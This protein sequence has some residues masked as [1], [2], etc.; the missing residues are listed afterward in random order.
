LALNR[1]IWRDNPELEWLPDNVLARLAFARKSL[2]RLRG[3]ARRL[4]TPELVEGII[5]ESDQI[6]VLAGTPGGEQK[7]ANLRKL[8]EMCRE[9]GTLGSAGSEEFTRRLG[10]LVES[11]PNEAKAPLLGEEAQVVR[12]MT[13]HQSKGL[14]FPLVILPDLAGNEGR[15][16][17]FTPPSVDGLFTLPPRDF[18]SDKLRPNPI[19]N[20]LRNLDKA[21][22][23]AE[24]ARLF[25][26]ACTRA[27]EQLV[28]C[29]NGSKRQTSWGKWV[30]Q[31]VLTDPETRIVDSADLGEPIEQS[32]ELVQAAPP[33]TEIAWEAGQILERSLNPMP[34]AP[35]LIRESVSGLEDWFACPRRYYYTRVLG[36]DTAVLTPQRALSKG[37]APPGQA[38]ALGSQ[39]HR[40]LEEA[41]LWQGP[42]SLHELSPDSED[43]DLARELAGGI[44][45]TELAEI[46]RDINPEHM[47]REQGFTLRIDGQTG[48]DLEIIGEID[49]LMLHSQGIRVIDYKVSRHIAPH[50][51]RVQLSLYALAAWRAGG[52]Q[53][54]IPKAGIC[55]LKESGAE[56]HWQS[57]GK[58]DLK[59]LELDLRQA[60][61]DIAALPLEPRL[62]DFMRGSGCGEACSLARAGLC[63]P[64]E[65]D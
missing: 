35:G 59:Q 54:D 24:T 49:L 3:M 42:Q 61:Q 2:A 55:Y 20:Q 47:F 62:K 39:V 48:P 63:S 9:T 11:P 51:Y 45:Q 5:E 25:Y 33:P 29:L 53:S 26:V 57:I 60:A 14:E 43:A 6:A 30:Q 16:S 31:L 17:Q 40:I 46:I 38:A 64:S 7:V 21:S 12:L 13:V 10:E 27:T 36:L 58:A 8:I 22:Q 18:I 23:E 34:P 32:D 1:A 19:Y 37:D 52:M 56:L 44:Y 50:D 65:D 41:P 4:K 28:F 15:P